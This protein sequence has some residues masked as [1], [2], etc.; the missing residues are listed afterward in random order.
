MQGAQPL[1]MNN[2][3][4]GNDVPLSP[5]WKL[6]AKPTAQPLVAAEK[7]ADKDAARAA[8]APGNTAPRWREE[9]RVDLARPQGD[10]WATGGED[11]RWNG[12]RAQPVGH[13]VPVVERW[14]GAGGAPLVENAAAGFG[15]VGLA[16]AAAGRGRGRPEERW[17]GTQGPGGGMLPMAVE[18]RPAAAPQLLAPAGLGAAAAAAAPGAAAA[19]VNGVEKWRVPG[20]TGVFAAAPTLLPVPSETLPAMPGRGRG[21]AVGRGRGGR[22]AA[23]PAAPGAVDR[24][25]VPPTSPGLFAPGSAGA[26]GQVG[27]FGS[28]LYAAPHGNAAKP[29]QPQQPLRYTQS[30]LHNVYGDLLAAAPPGRHLQ[31]PPGVQT[32]VIDHIY[33]ELQPGPDDFQGVPSYT[34]HHTTQPGEQQQQQQQVS[35]SQ[36]VDPRQGNSH[37]S[38]QP[39]VAAPAPAAPA[40][41]SS[42]AFLNDLWLYRDPKGDVQGPFTKVDILDWFEAGFFPQELPIR[43]AMESADAPFLPLSSM[44]KMWAHIGAGR[45]PPGFAPSA[46]AAAASPAPAAPANEPQAAPPVHQQAASQV[47][48]APA[49]RASLLETVLG[50]KLAERTPASSPPAQSH[51]HEAASAAAAGSGMLQ[52]QSL[53]QAHPATPPHQQQQ[54]QQ[55]GF[56]PSGT[57]LGGNFQ[58]GPEPKAPLL[59]DHFH[60]HQQQQQQQQG[61]FHSMLP[62]QQPLSPQQ[63]QQAAM[64]QQQHNLGHGMPP[65]HAHPQQQQHENVQQQQHNQQHNQQQQQFPLWSSGT[66][67]P[68]PAGGPP[69]GSD[70]S[71]KGWDAAELAK[72]QR[73]PTAQVQ[74]FGWVLWTPDAPSPTHPRSELLSTPDRGASGGGGMWGYDPNASLNNN[75]N[76]TNNNS[77]A[78]PHQQ[79]QHHTQQAH[80]QQHPNN[81]SPFPQQH[82]LQQQQQQQQ[83]GHAFAQQAGGDLHHLQQQQQQQRQAHEAQ[84]ALKLPEPL[85]SSAWGAA[86]AAAA[87][88]QQQQPPAGAAAAAARSLSDIQREQEVARAK[89]QQQYMQQ[90]QLDAQAAQQQ[91]QHSAQEQQQQQAA[92]RQLMQ[93]QHLQDLLKA[94]TSQPGAPRHQPPSRAE[95][96]PAGERSLSSSLNQ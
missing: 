84:E 76:N 55:G 34:M 69:Q 21:F 59:G 27:G 58:V 40:L 8:A 65:H 81:S 60:H 32:H 36:G 83:S 25:G 33:P 70:F 93:Q 71:F 72:Q 15:G 96:T 19:A 89:Q 31:I 73:Q 44:L 16:A 66:N 64:Q 39:Q 12:E 74:A 9:E 13:V 46:A 57:G 45:A 67:L 51:M 42:N 6:G 88:Q 29:N 82:S 4:H 11:A 38:N 23:L 28:V 43:A 37:S 63:Q 78:P 95:E 56:R 14:G 3:L 85:H 49:P 24:W 87:Q 7:W 52:S 2:G 80:L 17:A 22:G 77:M 48:T 90:Q 62:Q 91:Q 41:V 26:G 68:M 53:M 94:S 61:L 30:F 10:R 54:Q 47:L 92:A 18:H 50:K 86:P 35:H 20:V 1:S 79:Q 75:T 5:Q